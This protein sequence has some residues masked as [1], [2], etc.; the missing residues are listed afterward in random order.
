VVPLRGLP[1]A[2]GIL[3]LVFGLT[4]CAPDG[5][6]LPSATPLPIPTISPSPSAVD[7]PAIAIDTPA[8]AATVTVPITMRGTANT[9]EAALRIDAID[10]AGAVLC[11]RE[12]IATS[13]SGTPGDWSGTLAFP[14]PPPGA[15][16]MLRAYELSAKDGSITSLVTRVVTMSTARPAI[17]LSAP[18]CGT[19]VTRGSSVAVSGRAFVFEAQFTLELRDAAG[20][21][22]VA[23]QVF[24]TRGDT[25]SSFATSLTVPAGTP[26]GAYD[27]VAY[28]N[29]AAD[30]STRDE[31]AI[32]L[33]ID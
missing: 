2:A 17:I 13:G 22:V 32:P 6:V 3:I 20:A 4:G 25:E 18:S 26:I 30:G 7:S 12:L 29:D 31:F 23:Q 14:P 10:A 9:F 27:L 24:A 5:V 8:D 21:V 19:T 16:M 28:D 15:A 1:T 33:S 11:A